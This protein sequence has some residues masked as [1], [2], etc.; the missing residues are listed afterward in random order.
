MRVY[1]DYHIRGQGPRATERL[2]CL[3]LVAPM[4]KLPMS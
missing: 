1:T 2:A 3:K 4:S